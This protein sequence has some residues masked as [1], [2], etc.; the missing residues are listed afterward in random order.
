MSNELP[1][2]DLIEF[3]NRDKKAPFLDEYE[4][5]IWDDEEMVKRCE[6]WVLRNQEQSAGKPVQRNRIED[7]DGGGFRIL[8]DYDEDFVAALKDIVPYRERAWN[9]EAKVWVVNKSEYR[10]FVEPVFQMFYEWTFEE[11]EVCE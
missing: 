11:L 4:P 5:R 9:A 10:P 8:C 2:F 3:L 6:A 7:I 1:P